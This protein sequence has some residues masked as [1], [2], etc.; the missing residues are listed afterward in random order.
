[1]VTSTELNDQDIL[2]FFTRPTR[3]INHARIAEIRNDTKH[4]SVNAATQMELDS[5]LAAWP[6]I[7][8]ATGTHF[9][10]DELLVKAREAMIQ[11][12]QGFNNP[13][14]YFKSETFIVIAVIAYTYLLHWHYRRNGVDIRYRRRVDGIE[15]VSRTRH[16]ADKHWELE[17][18]LD[19]ADCPLDAPTVANLRFLITIRHEIEHQLTNRIDGAISAKLQ[20]CC[21]NFNRAIMDIA[22]AQHGLERDLALALQFS[23]ISRDH[24]DLLLSETDMPANIQAAHIEFEDGL[25]DEMVTDLRYSYRVAYVE[26]VVNSRGK[27]DQVIEFLRPGTEKGDH[28]RL[29]LK[30]VE[31]PKLKPGQIVALIQ[32]EGYPRFNV[33]HHTR[34]WQTA[35]A[36][37]PGKAFG[38]TLADGAWY[39]YPAWVDQVRTHV[40]ANAEQFGPA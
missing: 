33:H 30:E 3:S 18:C 37:A 4:R 28:V 9:I 29:A 8:H 7:D 19:Y 5:F 24:R 2:A 15:T 23:G 39:W 21:M 31:R 26:Q 13:R 12:V 20:A 40:Q 25:T 38:I 27:A 1:M 17:A 36:K 32:N 6:Q 34:L 11:A 22:G 16:G 35:D 14:A 10:G